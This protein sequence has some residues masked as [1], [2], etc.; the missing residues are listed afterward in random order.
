[1]N[2]LKTYLKKPW[3]AYTFSACAAV[4]FYIILSRLPAVA[5]A[6]KSALAFLSPIVIGVIT[7]YLL[8]PV[9]NFF[10]Q[11][12]F[13]KMKSESGR[14]TAGVILTLVFIVLLLVL[15]LASLR[16]AI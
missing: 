15:I 10:E 9:S 7:A 2:K 3:F 5:N 4:L 8:N 14:H 12:L 16:T 11:K 6:V 1:M 13:K